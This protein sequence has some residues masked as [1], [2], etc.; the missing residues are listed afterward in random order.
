M[1]AYRYAAAIARAGG[2]LRRAAAAGTMAAVDLGSGSGLLALMAAKQ[3]GGS[4]S[5]EGALMGV[6]ILSWL[7]PAPWS[8]VRGV[9]CLVPGPWSL[10]HGPWSMVHG[11]WS[12][13]PG[14]WSLVP[15]P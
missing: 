10:V 6:E 2:H 13:V 8:L 14:P 3:L 5:S 9:W 4:S 15:G 12:L 11:P 1:H 7:V